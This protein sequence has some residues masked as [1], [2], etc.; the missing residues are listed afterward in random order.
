MPLN[1]SQEAD[2]AG[3]P[4]PVLPISPDTAASRALDVTQHLP[5]PPLPW[6]PKIAGYRKSRASSLVNSNLGY[7]GGERILDLDRLA[8]QAVRRLYRRRVGSILLISAW[9]VPRKTTPS[10][11]CL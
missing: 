6:L 11:V 9:L 2:V 1:S 10:M 8:D 7:D 5:S 3:F 4:Q